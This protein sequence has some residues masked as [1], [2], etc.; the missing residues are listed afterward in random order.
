MRDHTKPR[1]F[2]AWTVVTMLFWGAV[3]F[4]TLPLWIVPVWLAF[5][6]NPD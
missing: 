3:G 1:Q 2:T 5:R 6:N 4:L